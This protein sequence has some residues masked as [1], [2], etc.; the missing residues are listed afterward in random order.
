VRAAASA[1]NGSPVVITPCATMCQKADG[2]L[3]G[4]PP[5][6]PASRQPPRRMDPAPSGLVIQVR[7]P[8]HSKSAAKNGKKRP[9]KHL[10]TCTFFANLPSVSLSYHTEA[11]LLLGGEPMVATTVV[12]QIRRMLQ[13]GRL[14]QR[15]IASRIGVSRGTVNA[16]AQGK[17]PLARYNGRH[18]SENG[19]IPP[20][21]APARCPGCGGRVQMPCL[22]CYIRS[23][24]GRSTS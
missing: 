9:K 2:L 20:S 4:P 5:H 24:S 19:F 7:I 10:Y 23:R 1:Q 22:L 12:D 14:S 17:K 3:I 15:R 18:P 16:I 8:P 11:W 21:G 6:P 13:E